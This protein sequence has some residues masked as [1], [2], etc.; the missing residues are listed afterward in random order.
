Y[1]SMTYAGLTSKI[2][3]GV[4]RNDPRVKAA[5]EW[6]SKYYSLQENPGLGTSGLYYY[7]HTFAKALDAIGEETLTDADGTK[8]NWRE[9]LATTLI[10]RQ[11]PDGSWA[12]DNQRWLEAD[13]N[14]STGYALMAL[15]Y[16]K[17]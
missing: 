11:R 13:A 12:N 14:L 17:K 9:E 6:I 3:A 2:Y 7:F 5:F 4:D 1:G 15:S 8:H 16:C 10:N